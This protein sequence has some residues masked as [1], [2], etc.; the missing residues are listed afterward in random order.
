MRCDDPDLSSEVAGAGMHN[1]KTTSV[2]PLPSGELYAFEVLL[3]DFRRSI[4]GWKLC[5]LTYFLQAGLQD[6]L[7]A[8]K[9]E[10]LCGRE[11]SAG[12]AS[13]AV[14]SKLPTGTAYSG[15]GKGGDSSPAQVK[16]MSGRTHPA[17][18][19]GGACAVEQPQVGDSKQLNSKQANSGSGGPEAAAGAAADAVFAAVDAVPGVL[20]LA[21]P[22]SPIPPVDLMRRILEAH[23]YD[24]EPVGSLSTSGRFYHRKPTPE[25]VSAPPTPPLVTLDVQM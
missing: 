6:A 22:A 13:A 11:P 10:S 24:P 18:E 7:N 23:R 14:C 2:L 19:E 17:G 3:L 20:E 16:P 21:L 12:E 4:V 9:P 8:R 1:I 5:P 25:Q 15:G